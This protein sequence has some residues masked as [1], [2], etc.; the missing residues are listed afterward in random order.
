[1][2]ECIQKQIIDSSIDISRKTNEQIFGLLNMHF[3]DAETTISTNYR[4]ECKQKNKIN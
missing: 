2:Q 3:K 4:N 1:M